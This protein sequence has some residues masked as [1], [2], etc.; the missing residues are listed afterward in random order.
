MA[1]SQTTTVSNRGAVFQAFQADPADADLA[2]DA[3]EEIR[4]MAGRNIYTSMEAHQ[5]VVEA[6]LNEMK[7]AISTLQWF[8]GIGFT[9]LM[10]AVIAHLF[11]G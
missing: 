4:E 2:Y 10:A 7:S 1:K 8:V 6:R 5:S 3:V 9:A 11:A